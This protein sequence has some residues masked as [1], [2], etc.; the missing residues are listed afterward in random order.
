MAALEPPGEKQSHHHC[1]YEHL[2]TQ[3][4]SAWQLTTAC[5]T[6]ENQENQ[7]SGASCSA[8]FI[9]GTSVISRSSAIV[10]KSKISGGEA[11]INFEPKE[12][13]DS[14]ESSIAQ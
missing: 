11:K 13:H 1:H 2:C 9:S 5:K 3:T 8:A 14:T 4:S 7:P 12:E 10:C 6:Y